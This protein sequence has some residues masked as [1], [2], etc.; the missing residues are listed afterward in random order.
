MTAEPSKLLALQGGCVLRVYRQEHG[1][2]GEVIMP[3]AGG[4]PGGTSLFQAPLHPGTDELEA[5]ANR[6]V[7]AYMEG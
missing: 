6:A 5:W 3:D 4:G 2:T 7:Q 1:V